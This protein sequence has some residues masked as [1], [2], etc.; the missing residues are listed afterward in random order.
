MT[1]DDPEGTAD[2]DDDPFDDTDDDPFDDIEGVEL[3]DDPFTDLSAGDEDPSTDFGPSD[4]TLFTDEGT[5][6]LDEEAVWERIEGDGEDGTEP[7]TAPELDA[8]AGP[9]RPPRSDEEDEGRETVVKKRSYCEQCEY[10]SEPPA[11]ACTYPDAEIVELVDTARFRVRNCPIVTRRRSN[12]LAAITEGGGTA[13]PELEGGAATDP[14]P[15][16]T[17]SGADD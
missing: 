8:G 17:D 14:E 5:T 10:F 1:E 6:D 15:E 3:E 11:V 16:A 4:N 12:D 13:D 7:E 2:D 9:D